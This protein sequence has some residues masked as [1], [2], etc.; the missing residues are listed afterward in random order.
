MADIYNFVAQGASSVASEGGNF[1]V[2]VPRMSGLLIQLFCNYI[3]LNLHNLAFESQNAESGIQKFGSITTNLL[4][5]RAELRASQPLPSDFKMVFSGPV[6]PYRSQRAVHVCTLRS[7]CGAGYGTIDVPLFVH[8]PAKNTI[9]SEHCFVPAWAVKTVDEEKDCTMH[10]KD[11]AVELKFPKW[12]E[13]NIF[14]KEGISDKQQP[15]NF[16]IRMRYLSPI[17]GCTSAGTMLTRLTKEDES[18]PKRKRGDEIPDDVLNLIGAIG[19][20]KT[21]QAEGEPAA[22]RSKA[23]VKAEF[24]HLLK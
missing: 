14:E 12:L 15:S 5:D 24:A 10:V 8:G 19:M 2:T 4:A 9:C 1:I 18:L 11:D 22:K 16:N 3:Q 17:V 20:K 23:S 13:T 21:L 6:S 7:K